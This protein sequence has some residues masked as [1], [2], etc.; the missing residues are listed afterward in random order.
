MNSPPAPS[1]AS[2]DSEPVIED[3]DSDV[4][5]PAPERLIPA[6]RLRETPPTVPKLP[7]TYAVPL[8]SSTSTS[9]TVLLMLT[10]SAPSAPLAPSTSAIRTRLTPP[11]AVKL[12]TSSTRPPGRTT[13]SVTGWLGVPTA[14]PRAR[15]PVA[16]SRPARRRNTTPPTCEKSP[17]T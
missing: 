1:S 11:T 17:P 5:D 14:N 12:P 7:A 8:A 16:L 15:C 6:S 9:L 10:S 13:R 4:T 3:T 2:A